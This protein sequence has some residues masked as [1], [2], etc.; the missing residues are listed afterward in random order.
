MRLWW[1]AAALVTVLAVGGFA[2]WR[3]A[4]SPGANASED[5]AVDRNRIA[6]MYFE[7]RSGSD[8]L[9][10]LADGLTEGLIH[11]LSVVK[12]LQVISRNGVA[13]FRKA[14]A[15]PDRKAPLPPQN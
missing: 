3:M 1:V 14:A 5:P 15:P 4:L 8:S 11:E 7:N 12:P 2:A 13:P 10:Y 6:V 9:G